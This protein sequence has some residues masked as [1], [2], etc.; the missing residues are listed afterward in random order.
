MSI[1]QSMNLAFRYYRGLS[2]L[3]EALSSKK[4]DRH[5]DTVPLQ[6]QMMNAPPSN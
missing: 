6:H 1:D 4:A 5:D 2:N 3:P